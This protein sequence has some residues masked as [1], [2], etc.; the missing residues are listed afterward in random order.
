MRASESA[1]E[2]GREQGREYGRER[3]MHRFKTRGNNLLSLVEYSTDVHDPNQRFVLY[4]QPLLCFGFLFLF[5][6][7][8]FSFLVFCDLCV[9]SLSL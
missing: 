6:I 5:L 3:R 7:L 4:W 1:R 8:C 9:S 2:Q